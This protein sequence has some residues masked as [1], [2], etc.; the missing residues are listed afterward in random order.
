MTR[1][2]LAVVGTL[3]DMVNDATA[4]AKRLDGGDYTP[5]GEAIYFDS[6]RDLARVLSPK[7]TQLLQHLK[8]SGAM[9]ILALS[10]HLG[11]DYKNVHSDVKLLE[12]YGLIARDGEKI[13]APYDVIHADFDLRKAA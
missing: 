9:N 2:V 6:A 1:Q 13:T 4:M 7:R 3:D 8:R 12:Q 11:R 5:A 10:K